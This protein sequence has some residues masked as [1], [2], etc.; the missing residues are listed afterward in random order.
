MELIELFTGGDAGIRQSLTNLYRGE[1]Q[2][3]AKQG[4]DGGLSDYVRRAV[5]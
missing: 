1:P 3:A 5:E 2:F 4:L